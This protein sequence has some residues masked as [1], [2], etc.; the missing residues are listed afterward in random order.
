MVEALDHLSSGSR[1]RIQYSSFLLAA[2]RGHFSLLICLSFF[3]LV[4]F[5]QIFIISRIRFWEE[6]ANNLIHADIRGDF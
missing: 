2:F 4:R 1:N 3:R 5:F 6:E